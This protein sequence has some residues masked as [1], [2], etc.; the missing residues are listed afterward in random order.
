MAFVTN[1]DKL[2]ALLDACSLTQEWEIFYL[3]DISTKYTQRGAE[4][5]LFHVCLTI[6]ELFSP[7]YLE[8]MK[9]Y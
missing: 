8:E 3:A 7:F 5:A 1:V 6:R 9:N 2:Q 4:N